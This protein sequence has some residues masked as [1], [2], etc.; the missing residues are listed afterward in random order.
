MPSAGRAPGQRDEGSFAFDCEQP[1]RPFARLARLKF[2]TGVATPLEGPEAAKKRRPSGFFSKLFQI[3]VCF[4]QAF[5][6]K[7]LAVLW[8]FKGLRGF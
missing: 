3:A 8:G 2:A 7:A 4:L 6:K 1:L 5:P